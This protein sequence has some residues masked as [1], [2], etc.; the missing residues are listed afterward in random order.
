MNKTELISTVVLLCLLPV[1]HTEGEPQQN[2]LLFCAA[3]ENRTGPDAPE[4]IQCTRKK[5]FY[6]S[7]FLL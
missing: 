5:Q 1:L 3:P 7:E 6:S 2:N 4:N